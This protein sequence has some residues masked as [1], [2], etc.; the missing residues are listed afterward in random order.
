M[1]VYLLWTHLQLQVQIGQMT[2]LFPLFRLY[3]CNDITT[4]KTSFPCVINIIYAKKQ[5]CQ[6]DAMGHDK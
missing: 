5:L 3:L 2:A 1:C 4:K 6:K